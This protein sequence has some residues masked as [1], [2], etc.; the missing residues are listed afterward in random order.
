M[1]PGVVT[2]Y[3][4][5]VE[6]FDADGNLLVVAP[7]ELN[8]SEPVTPTH[9]WWGSVGANLGPYRGQHLVLRTPEGSE[10]A[11]LV[12]ES[13]LSRSDILGTGEPPL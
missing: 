3:Y 11:F 10:G 12:E 5:E 6:I 2:R 8:R 1:V 9:Q 13:S 4:L 7:A